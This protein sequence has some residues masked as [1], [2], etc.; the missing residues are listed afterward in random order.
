ME[1]KEYKLLKDRERFFWWNVGRRR[2]LKDALRRHAR[3]KTGNI[4]DVGCGPGGNI[5][6]LRE[7][8]EVV[9]VDSNDEAL[10]YAEAEGYKKIV[11]GSA[12]ELPF[13]NNCFDGASALDVIEHIDD[14]VRALHEIFRILKPGGFFLLTVPAYKWMW[15]EH[16]IALH[17]KRRYAKKELL[18]KIMMA[19]FIIKESSHFVFLSIPFRALKF[20]AG[21][22]FRF[23]R[24]N[25]QPKTDDIIL[26]T[27]LNSL[28]IFWLTMERILMKIIPIPW[29]SSIL[30]VAQ[31]SL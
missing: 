16:D 25:N 24:K 8:G 26:P 22:A 1:H 17:H 3:L 18:E 11:R 5:L 21:K 7:F 4:L 6:F 12:T 13:P 23:S 27:F 15:S 30:V 19:G 29:G 2:I 9:G 20:F 10:R 28:L 31:K 14:D